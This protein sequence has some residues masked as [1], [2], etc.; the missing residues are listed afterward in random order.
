MSAA[1][2]SIN[3]RREERRGLLARIDD[4]VNWPVVTQL[5]AVGAAVAMPSRLTIINGVDVA[6]LVGVALL[7]VW[8]GAL[9]HYRGARVVMALGVLALLSGI[10]LTFAFPGDRV[11]V[12]SLLQ[13]D[14][15]VFLVMWLGI[16]V[17]L[18]V[19]TV[20]GTSWTIVWWALGEIVSGITHPSELGIPWKYGFGIPITAILLALLVRR[21]PRPALEVPLALVLAGVFA[22]ND[23]RSLFGLTVL[24]A[25]VGVLQALLPPG[26]GR[27]RDLL[28]PLA[29]LGVAAYGVYRAAMWAI[30]AGFLGEAARTRTVA[31]VESAGSLLVGG[32]PEVGASLALVSEQP[33]GYGN[34]LM[35]SRDDIALGSLGMADLSGRMPDPGYVEQYMFFYGYVMHS[36]LAEFWIKYGLFGLAFLLVVAVLIVAG[37]LR[38]MSHG[39]LTV[40]VSFLAVTTLWNLLFSPM[41]DTVYLLALT[42]AITLASRRCTPR[43]ELDART[44]AGSPLGPRPPGSRP[45]S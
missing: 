27:I 22:L 31:Q 18:W 24:A 1:P 34:G 3:A 43:E 2:A 28:A 19:R 5:L 30:G 6:T 33:W 20:L 17:L 13:G 21:G 23:S 32:R 26:R 12:R 7:P 38:L 35:A 36:T 45:G 44:R 10:V 14:V 41:Q 8:W 4:G 25:M 9:R 29:V 39:L 37:L 11:V 40:V 15:G 16:G 42:A